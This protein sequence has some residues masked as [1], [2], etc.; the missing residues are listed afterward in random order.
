VRLAE[1]AAAMRL[2]VAAGGEGDV[3]QLPV[4]PIGFDPLVVSPDDE[5]IDPL[6]HPLLRR[7]AVAA[8]AISL[9]GAAW[10]AWRRLGASPAGRGS[11]AGG[12][13]RSRARA[14]RRGRA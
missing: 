3:L 6:A 11:R 9:A 7:G 4:R 1:A 8:S 13:A 2:P 14:T 12:T 10:I 5:A